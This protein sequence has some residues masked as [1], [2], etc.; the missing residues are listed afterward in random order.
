[1]PSNPTY[2]GPFS[3]AWNEGAPHHH[4]TFD[5]EPIELPL[6]RRWP[7]VVITSALIIALGVG[8]LLI[9]RSF[10]TAKLGPTEEPEITPRDG[11]PWM[12]THPST[13]HA[14]PEVD[15]PEGKEASDEPKNAEP[16]ELSPPPRSNSQRVTPR[17]A[18]RSFAVSSGPRVNAPE[19]ARSYDFGAADSLRPPDEPAFDPEQL[20]P[21]SAL[22]PP[23]RAASDDL[24]DADVPDG[25]VPDPDD[26]DAGVPEPEPPRPEPPPDDE[27]DPD[28]SPVLGF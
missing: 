7:A 5:D 8:L 2:P 22:T 4:D 17:P 26:P 27:N 3:R 9:Q 10:S 16:E 1:M 28:Y 25:D 18:L 23:T 14:V 19:P 15:K 12:V 6:E 11:E 24:P 20:A 13:A 21:S